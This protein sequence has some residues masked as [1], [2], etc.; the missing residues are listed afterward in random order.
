[1]Y[2]GILVPVVEVPYF[3]LYEMFGDMGHDRKKAAV[4]HGRKLP[5]FPVAAGTAGS[6]IIVYGSRH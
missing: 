5:D 6:T 3:R 1:L 4:R 2:R